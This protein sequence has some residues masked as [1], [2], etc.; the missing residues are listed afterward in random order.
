MPVAAQLPGK[1]EFFL[2]FVRFED[3]QGKEVNIRMLMHRIKLAGSKRQVTCIISTFIDHPADKVGVS[4]AC[5][6]NPEVR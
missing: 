6:I 2:E 1:T 4:L 3:S 5:S